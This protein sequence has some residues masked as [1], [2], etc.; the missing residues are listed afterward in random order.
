M[1]EKERMQAF[2]GSQIGETGASYTFYSK[3]LVNFCIETYFEVS[4][5]R[6]ELLNNHYCWGRK[7]KFIEHTIYRGMLS[8]W[9][10]HKPIQENIKEQKMYNK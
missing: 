3:Y 9:N 8:Q 10:L 2:I 4:A 6:K 5:T 1:G 7:R